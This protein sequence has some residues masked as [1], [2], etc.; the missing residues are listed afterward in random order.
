M[1][2]KKYRL[3]EDALALIPEFKNGRQFT[4]VL[5]R[6]GMLLV[7][8]KQEEILNATLLY[9]GASLR[10]ARDGAKSILG[11]IK[12]MPIMVNETLGHYWFP[13]ISPAKPVC[14]WLALHHIIS[15]ESIDKTHTKVWLSGGSFIIVPISKKSLEEKIQRTCTLRYEI[16]TRTARATEQI[17]EQRTTYEVSKHSGQLNY[18]FQQVESKEYMNR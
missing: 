8:E 15:Y 16:E 6:N 1:E 17:R 7:E 11:K 3:D 10:G 14:I 4:K 12:K 5:T 9:Y 13:V 18:T 2:L